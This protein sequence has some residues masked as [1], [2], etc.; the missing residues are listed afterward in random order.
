MKNSSI[1][2]LLIL[3]FSCGYKSIPLKG[4]YDDKP[5]VITTP[6]S[7]STVWDKTIDLFAQRGIGIK[8][9][10]RSSGL[11]VAQNASAPVTSED[12]KGNLINKEAWVVTEKIY[13]PG[14]RKY[15]YSTTANIEWNIR[16]KELPGGSTS[17]NI[18]LIN[19]EI[20][21]SAAKVNLLVPASTSSYVVKSPALST[22][23]FENMIAEII[24]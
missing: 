4:K 19:V 21:T 23:V 8:L 14:P 3:L 7:F 11:I 1:S 5:F 18:N 22:R 15:Y 16:I 20:V 9:I 13:D 2:I 10:D 6:S 12:S 24:K 17:I